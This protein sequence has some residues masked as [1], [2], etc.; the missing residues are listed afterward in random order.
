[1][2]KSE[3]AGLVAAVAL[4]VLA[5]CS[6]A[7][8]EAP[9]SPSTSLARIVADAER[10]GSSQEQLDVLS[11]ALKKGE[12][13]YEAL[14]SLIV[15][16]QECADGVGAEIMVLTPHQEP[17][18]LVSPHLA[19]LPH[20]GVEQDEVLNAVDQC[21]LRTMGYAEAFYH[22][23]PAALEAYDRYFDTHRDTLI[24]CLA[25]HGLDMPLESTIDEI[26]ATLVEDRQLSSESGQ[27]PC[28]TGESLAVRRR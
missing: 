10:G 4:F 8:G 21:S 12:L 9:Q 13:S 11:E 16:F 2:K 24:A 5:G 1:M 20:D 3:R 26:V 28:Y 14:T 23:Q 6:T 15:D 18:G 27:A 7:P 22:G 25:G 17:W 19:V